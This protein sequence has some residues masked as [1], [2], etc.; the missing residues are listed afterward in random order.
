MKDVSV[1]FSQKSVMAMVNNQMPKVYRKLMKGCVTNEAINLDVLKK[2][3]TYLEREYRNEYYFKNTIFNKL[4]LGVH[5]T[6]TTTV[7]NEV[8]IGNSRADLIMLNG[9]PVVYEIKTGLDNFYKIDKQFSDYYSC[10]P[11]VVL[12]VDENNYYKAIRKRKNSK[13]PFGVYLMHNNSRIHKEYN[14]EAYDKQIENDC[15]YEIF[16]RKEIETIL[17]QQC[18]RIPDADDFTRYMRYRDCF[19]NININSK[20]YDQIW[21]ILKERHSMRNDVIKKVP[22]ELKSLVYFMNLKEKDVDKLNWYLN[23]KVGC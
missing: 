16:R 5:S 23:Q 11:Y 10:F 18:G 9:S 14:P 21:N 12:V 1:L 7:L 8:R 19:R 15:I 20:T 13:Y 4:F 17:K 22:Y 3:Y 2:C 6:K